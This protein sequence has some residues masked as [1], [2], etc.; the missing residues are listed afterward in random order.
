MFE[1]SIKEN[2][3]SNNAN[4]QR[5]CM[6]TC[7]TVL[8]DSPHVHYKNALDLLRSTYSVKLQGMVQGELSL[9]VNV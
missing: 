7:I 1:S 5:R 8:C 2:Q 9:A 4:G 3:S 6:R